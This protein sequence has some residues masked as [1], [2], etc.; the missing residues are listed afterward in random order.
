MDNNV[1]KSESESDKEIAFKAAESILEQYYG[2]ELKRG[3]PLIVARS[4]VYLLFPY[5]SKPKEISNF[6]KD[7]SELKEGSIE[8]NVRK[9]FGEKKK[10]GW[11][12]RLKIPKLNTNN[13][14]QNK[15]KS[16]K[17]IKSDIVYSLRHYQ[18]MMISEITSSLNSLK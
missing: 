9:A 3:E 11:R 8:P 4:I 13:N 10:F 6:I 1:K 16:S 7:R 18:D 15:R 17:E 2:H 5:F 14:T 12:K